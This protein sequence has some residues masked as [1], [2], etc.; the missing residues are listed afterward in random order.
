MYTLA[1]DILVFHQSICD[2]LAFT[3][4][5]RRL[6]AE[7]QQVFSKAFKVDPV[8]IDNRGFAPLSRRRLWWIGGKKP[9]WPE[10]GQHRTSKTGAQ[11]IRPGEEP[12]AWKQCLLPGYTPCTCDEKTGQPLF[13]CLAPKMATEGPEQPLPGT[14]R[15][16]PMFF[17]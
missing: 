17:S 5:C 8:E 14:P 6:A 11:M 1:S 13:R 12:V 4:E 3:F 16:Q 10:T 7:D 15:L 9:Q 2:N